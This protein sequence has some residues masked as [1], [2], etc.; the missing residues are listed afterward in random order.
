MKSKK[1][2]NYESY[3]M[4]KISMGV[5]WWESLKLHNLCNVR[6]EN[7]Q[8]KKKQKNM[9]KIIHR[10]LI[11]CKNKRQVNKEFVYKINFAF[12]VN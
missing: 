6:K 7:Q 1:K 2:K 12:A 9:S 11:I 4:C 5:K 8:K 10:L 3:E